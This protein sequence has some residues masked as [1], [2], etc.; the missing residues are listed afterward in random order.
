MNAV[1]FI[2]QDYTISISSDGLP[3]GKYIY[4]MPYYS[5]NNLRK[6]HRLDEQS[7]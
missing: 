4:I 6:I 2:E 7:M 1:A 3:E 5:S